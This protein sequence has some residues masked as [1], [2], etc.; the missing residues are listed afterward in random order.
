MNCNKVNIIWEFV[1][2][3]LKIHLSFNENIAKKSTKEEKK[4]NYFT[5][6]I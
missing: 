2:Y 5:L 1:L 6:D 3:F 4:I